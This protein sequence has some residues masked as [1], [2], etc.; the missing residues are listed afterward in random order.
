MINQAPA[1]ARIINSQVIQQ[2]QDQQHQNV[3][4]NKTTLK[5]ITLTD[6]DAHELIE[7][8]NGDSSQDLLSNLLVLMPS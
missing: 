2:L 5:D 4:G 1:V 6:T 7:M 3:S 8:F